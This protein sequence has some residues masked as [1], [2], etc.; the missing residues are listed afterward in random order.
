[1]LFAN[2]DGVVTRFGYK[3]SPFL[4][5]LESLCKHVTKLLKVASTRDEVEIIMADA[6]KR[7]V[8]MVIELVNSA[9]V[10]KSYIDV[11]SHYFTEDGYGKLIPLRPRRYCLGDRPWEVTADLSK[12]IQQCIEDLTDMIWRK[13]VHIDGELWASLKQTNCTYKQL[14]AVC[15]LIEEVSS[16]FIA[17][18]KREWADMDHAN[19]K[20]VSDFADSRKTELQEKIHDMIKVIHRY[21]E[22]GQINLN[23]K[24]L[25]SILNKFE[26]E[27]ENLHSRLEEVE[28][29]MDDIY[30]L[31]LMEMFKQGSGSMG[32][33]LKSILD[34]L[35]G[36]DGKIPS[37]RLE[38]LLRGA[39]KFE[40]SH[41]LI[42]VKDEGDNLD[43]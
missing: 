24:L 27:S 43:I 40:E 37:K 8:H 38:E 28:E 6:K 34:I 9:G 26:D 42:P 5:S 23:S 41:S 36:I 31:D 3:V 7:F 1:M 25:L 14:H 15:D 19:L 16:E 33:K 30:D 4:D 21:D 12:D 17:W 35:Q 10:H 20:S 32:S 18:Q 39:V 29:G 13:T 22:N 2:I 11:T